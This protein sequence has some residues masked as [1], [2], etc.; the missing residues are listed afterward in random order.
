MLIRV[1]MGKPSCGIYMLS[2]LLD[3]EVDGCQVKANMSRKRTLLTCLDLPVS[4]DT[5]TSSYNKAY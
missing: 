4:L 5:P 1:Q 3:L 2:F